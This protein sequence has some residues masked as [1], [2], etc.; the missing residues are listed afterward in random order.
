MWTDVASVGYSHQ[1]GHP[2]YV[3]GFSEE[4]PVNKAPTCINYGVFTNVDK[5]D[6]AQIKRDIEEANKIA[7]HEL[8]TMVESNQL[9]ESNETGE[10][11]ET[12]IGSF[13]DEYNTH[14]MGGDY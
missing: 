4:S 2:V 1:V 6:I 12:D 14:Y 3:Y 8:F 7:G 13:E 11:T 9:D 5:H 10:L